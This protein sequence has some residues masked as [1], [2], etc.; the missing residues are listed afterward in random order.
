MSN[1]SSFGSCVPKHAIA[2]VY[3]FP[4]VSVLTFPEFL[5]P[6]PCFSCEKYIPD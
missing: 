2:L 1:V 4:G 5:Q 3:S 6:L